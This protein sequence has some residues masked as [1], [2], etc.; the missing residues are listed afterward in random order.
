MEVQKCQCT[1][2][3]SHTHFC[4]VPWCLLEH[5]SHISFLHVHACTKSDH[6]QA[7]IRPRLLI[8]RCCKPRECYPCSLSRLLLYM[9]NTCIK[10]LQ[11]HSHL[12][13][14]IMVP[15]N[16]LE[17]HT[18]LWTTPTDPSRYLFFIVDICV[19]TVCT[20]NIILAQIQKTCLGFSYIDQ[21][22]SNSSLI[23]I[24]IQITGSSWSAVLTQ[25]QC[26]LGDSGPKILLQ[27][28]LNIS[29]WQ[30]DSIY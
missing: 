19:A 16:L 5:G 17:S 26:W 28:H 3:V 6:A 23:R 4:I 29:F 8:D 2:F 22:Q 11:Y 7:C 14:H 27:N 1:F 20:H 18:V 12:L 21:I 13:K 10:P 9:Q 24:A 15:V 30:L 25:F